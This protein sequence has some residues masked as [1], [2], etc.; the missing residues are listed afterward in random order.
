MP[1]AFDDLIPQAPSAA[2]PQG[3]AFDD[4]VPQ[5]QTRAAPAPAPEVQW[6]PNAQSNY[7]RQSAPKPAVPSR[8]AH[9]LGQVAVPSPQMSET[10]ARVGQHWQ[11]RRP[12]GS[13]RVATPGELATRG[14][15]LPDAEGDP[16]PP[17]QVVA[18][19]AAAVQDR[20]SRERFT[21]LTEAPARGFRPDDPVGLSLEDREK[22]AP[23]GLTYDPA[24]NKGNPVAALFDP[25][26]RGAA[27]AADVVFSRA[28][29]AI[30]ETAGSVAENVAPAVGG[31][32][33]YHGRHARGAAEL[34]LNYP[35]LGTPSPRMTAGV[36]ARQQRAFNRRAQT[37]G[38]VPEIPTEPVQPPVP[39]RPPAAT[40][41]VEPPPR[42]AVQP[43]PTPERPATEIGPQ[44][45]SAGPNPFSDLIPRERI[46]DT[47]LGIS[48]EAIGTVPEKGIVS[49]ETPAVVPTPEAI[50]EATAA[51][52]EWRK[53]IPR[54][55]RSPDILARIRQLG[56]L[57]LKMADGKPAPGAGDVRQIL[58]GQPNYGLIDNRRG[59]TP[60]YMREA[61]S[62]EG[63]LVRSDVNQT[64]D[65]NDFF[66]LLDRGAREKVYHPNSRYAAELET[67]RGL[68]REMDAAGI[69]TSDA[70]NVAAQKLA[71][72][73]AARE[74][75]HRRAQELAAQVERDFETATPEITNAH[76]AQI[77][78]I[79]RGLG[80][81][82]L[83]VGFMTEVEKADALRQF[84]RS[85]EPPRTDPAAA[86][87]Q[88]P[89]APRTGDVAGAGES[90]EPR[91][92]D[93]GTRAA[94]TGPERPLGD[95]LDDIP[96]QRPRRPRFREEAG[97]EGLPQLVIPGA[98]RSAEQL[99][100]ARETEGRGR[101]AASRE[102]KAADEGLFETKADDE[103]TLFQEP[104]ASIPKGW[105]TAD[106][107]LTPRERLHGRPLTGFPLSEL[108][109]V[110]QKI[111][112]A[113]DETV[114]RLIPTAT[115]QGMRKLRV[116]D[117]QVLGANYTEGGRRLVAWSLESP[118]AVGTARHE[119][120]H[121]LKRS[122]LITPDEWS[123]LESA[124]RDGN[125]VEK[126][127]IESRYYS[128]AKGTHIEEAVAEEFATWRRDRH[129]VPGPVRRIFQKVQTALRH[130]GEK[131]R[132]ILGRDVTAEDV[133]AR[134]ERGEVGRRKPSSDVTGPERTAHQQPKSTLSDSERSILSHVGEQGERREPLL[135]FDKIYTATIDELHPVKRMVEAMSG[136]RKLTPSENAY[137]L[138]R[139]N[140][141]DVG[142]ADHMLRY[143]TFDPVTFKDNG[144][145]LETILKPVHGQLDSFK[146]YMVARRAVELH[147]RNIESGVP[148][149]TARK[150]V[151]DADPLFPL[152][153]DQ[154]QAF[155]K[156]VLS[157][158][159][160][161]G[162]I[163]GE[164]RAAIEEANKSYVPFY[165]VLE[166][167]RYTGVGK[168]GMPVRNPVKRIKGSK[169]QILDPIE[170]TI[171][172][173]YAIARVAD[174]SAALNAL[175]DLGEKTGSG[176][177]EKVPSSM[178]PITVS[179][180]EVARLLSDHGIP[181]DEA[182][183]FTIF[184]PQ[185]LRLA[186]DE[187]A[188][189][190]DGKMTVYRIPPEVAEAIKGLDDTGVRNIFMQ[191]MAGINKMFKAGVTLSPDF[192]L[193]N[194]ARD[195]FSAFIQSN[196]GKPYIPVYGLARGIG[197]MATK[198][199]PYRMWLKSG[200][201][202]STFNA[203]DRAH[204]KKM[205]REISSDTKLAKAWNV[206]RNPVEMMAALAR[207]TEVGTRVGVM[208]A[209]LKK[210]ASRDD[211]LEAALNSRE[212][213]LDFARIGARTKALN[214]I[215][216]FWNPQV[217][218]I[219]TMAR[220]FRSNPAAVLTKALV[221]ITIPTMLLWW[222][223][224]DDERYRETP[225]WARDLFWII[226]TD[227]DPQSDPVRIP[228]PFEWGIIFGSA[229]E[230][231][232]DSWYQKD[233]HAWDGF[234]DTIINSLTPGVM[235]TALVP[236]YEQWANKSMFTNSPLVPES[237]EGL[238][239]E[240]RYTDSTSESVKL[241]GQGI[242]SLPG[243]KESDIA[244]PAVLQ[245][246]IRQWTGGLG[247]YGLQAA[248]EVLRATGAAPDVRPEGTLADIPGLKAF[249]LR[250]PSAQARSI[251]QF[252][253]TYNS[254]KMA[255]DTIRRLGRTG[256]PAERAR[257][258]E[259][260]MKAGTIIR[261]DG[262][263]RA[264]RA[265][266]KRVQFIVRDPKMAPAEKRRLIDKAYFDMIRLAQ[267]GNDIADRAHGVTPVRRRREADNAAM[268]AAP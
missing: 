111:A 237:L 53:P 12:D 33:D 140:K 213:T 223:N 69:A 200:A 224:K 23:Y 4:L 208:R 210:M 117:D 250:H 187:I 62:E 91:A 88:E 185:A 118:D 195:Q 64:T 75:E 189:P 190:R 86:S 48:P 246:Y 119:A 197:D 60:D 206:A 83:D 225:D 3:N 21:A 35:G 104:R 105:E 24:V 158:L 207:L 162:R 50:A 204:L 130:V 146:A 252:Y 40:A 160:K 173:V 201:A 15:G 232:M 46:G 129:A 159:E 39:T 106:G 92:P 263:A 89:V 133:F 58:D 165:R 150:V 116:G 61:L 242:A 180:A 124:A 147:E 196:K 221:G 152:T 151:A 156:R 44:P 107:G 29:G 115:V 188:V 31:S 256:R 132:S 57:R 145:S 82:P 84:G 14:S 222:A 167:E 123:T 262:I 168:S 63:W 114:R 231:L 34:A 248:D 78:D 18:A 215:I 184:R 261:L 244:S 81:D 30:I 255:S 257:E 98:E 217:Q 37:E 96:F 13:Y 164:M 110:E 100:K 181:A 172:N 266:Q 2:S 143:G 260:A 72:Y 254:H 10:W 25:I 235:P 139:L 233:P 112:K 182:A 226:P 134:I 17:P 32:P 45:A 87:G 170:S 55:D 7:G 218:G 11:V 219:D 163:S 153:F 211:I 183:A 51:V 73:R 157:Y 193:R 127:G 93:A 155:N 267:R 102:Q 85:Q 54:A 161:S 47:G 38:A 199:E 202:N 176:L 74:A 36:S 90:T 236:V 166:D 66:D 212:A 95:D 239:P 178:R 220:K 27:V 109:P 52:Q 191:A 19:Q 177:I 26:T 28:P 67:R 154:Y 22:L 103:P 121:F 9:A 135:D 79:L 268:E 227:D 99:A 241:L 230:R 128:E 144:P 264:L 198:S 41:P 148:I 68:D 142:K 243:M 65:L 94:G 70:P 247:M 59:L 138:L 5:R 249:M 113:V 101:I 120:I 216:A 20:R 136:G 125:W 77:D 240:Y 174:R 6:S 42:P 238:L 122:G 141:G 205:A 179:D 126:Y 194:P 265:R 175:V 171:R 169:R 8:V 251:R 71:N 203:I 76:Q 214:Q 97:A 108:T 16:M 245:N 137:I 43:V 1:G 80:Y 253:D 228:K 131:V 56:G 49:R 259:E 229:V 258:R 186:K 209:G 234:G 192:V 149:E